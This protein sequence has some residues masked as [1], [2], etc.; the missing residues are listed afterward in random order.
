MPGCRAS[1]WPNDWG[2]SAGAPGAWREA[3]ARR[4][5]SRGGRTETIAE[6]L[7]FPE[8]VAN[9][10]TL[11]RALG[12]APRPRART[13]GARRPRDP[14]GRARGPARRRRLVAADA[15]AARA[16][17]ATARGC[18]RRSGRSSPSCRRPC[19]GCGSSSRSCRSRAGSSSSS[20]RRRADELRTRLRE[21]LRQVRASAGVG[22][23]LHRRGGRAVVAN[24]GSSEHCSFRATTERSRGRRSS[25]PISTGCRGRSSAQ[26]SPSCARSG[27]SSTAGGRRSRST[28]ATSR[29]CSRPARTA[30][31]SATR[32]ARPGSRSVVR[33]AAATSSSGACRARSR[34]ARGC[35]GTAPGPA[36]RAP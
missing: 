7:E 18:A 10:L 25:R 21:G 13:R 33:E 8:A 17:P 34:R 14:Q 3:K 32:S 1:P 5:S 11:R 12:V 9:E 16:R 23:G 2:R 4:G 31:S 6:A 26:P 19:C 36:A 28:A 24:P 20:S 15:H 22:V 27:A 35:S 30:S 29:S